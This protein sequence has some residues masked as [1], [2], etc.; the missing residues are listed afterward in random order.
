MCF[1]LQSGSASLNGFEIPRTWLKG[2]SDCAN[3]PLSVVRVAMDDNDNGAGSADHEP[4]YPAAVRV[5]VL[6]KTAGY[7]H[8]SIPSGIAAL[9]RLGSTSSVPVVAHATEDSRD[10]LGIS[11]AE[12]H[13]V[14]LL[15][16]SGDFLDAAELA[17]LRAYARAGG[18]I[19]GI[20]CA[21]A[22]MPPGEGG[23]GNAVDGDGWY[24]RGL[25]GAAFAGHPE[26]QWG[27]VRVADPEHPILARGKGLSSMEK[28]AEGGALE[29]KWYDEWYNFHTNPRD[30]N[31]VLLTCDES[32]FEGGTMGE[33]HPLAWCREV[34]G[35]RSFYTALGH[36]DE[37]YTDETFM[38]HILNGILWSARR[39]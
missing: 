28:P 20:H 25:I 31:H 30:N 26:P 3:R 34:D 18:G 24:A 10:L 11:P 12:Y 22:G 1:R 35:M 23:S 7:R 32:S 21:A 8:E 37:A 33:D 15:Q 6:S 38:A 2:L 39:I 27:V 19:V 29:W 14:V 13:V 16:T 9:H 36:F 5:L 4:F 17:A